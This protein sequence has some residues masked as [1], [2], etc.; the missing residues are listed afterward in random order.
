MNIK[1]IA[2]DLDRTT[3]DE[4]G[5]LSEGN[6][7]ALCEVMKK[8]IHVIIASGRSFQVLPKD[9]LVLP[10][11]EYAVTGNGSAM[12]HIPSG[13]C[14]KQCLLCPQ[15]IEAVLEAVH[16]EDAACEAFMDGRAYA[17]KKELDRLE[18]YGFT[19]HPAAYVRETRIPVEDIRDFLRKHKE[20]M[21][22]MDV[23]AA[24]EA[25]RKRI[26]ERIEKNTRAAYIT[27]SIPQLIEV[28]HKDTGKHHGVAFLLEYLG[29]RPEELAAFGDGDNDID[30][31]RYAGYG[32][33]MSNGTE[34]CKAAADA[35]TKHHQED[36]VAYGLREILG[37]IGT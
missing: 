31:L 27:S 1:C 3:L 18:Y 21:E 7:L 28:S 32:I 14:M 20:H 11:I 19:G 2:L 10:G 17:E 36:G 5:R 6:R 34:G 23:V 13:R 30:L 29:L 26:R 12:Y 4:S 33:A 37:V 24:E 16:G 15:D 8:G 25:A 35:I 22:G 9:I